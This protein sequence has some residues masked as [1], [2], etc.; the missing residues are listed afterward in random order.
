MPS[1]G[2]D[3]RFATAADRAKNDGALADALRALFATDTARTWFDRLDAAGAPCEISD[4]HF[5]QK[6][7]DDPEFI[8]RKLVVNRVG[9][10]NL[11]PV[12]LIG[13]LIDFSDTPTEPGGAPPVMWQ[14]TREIMRE[15]GYS[16]ADIDKLTDSGAV[17]LPQPVAALA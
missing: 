2:G 12:D 8:A 14:H 7:F 13:T 16:D 11:G 6:V 4:A 15:L 5:S 3:A 1:L 17:V 9:N 10:P